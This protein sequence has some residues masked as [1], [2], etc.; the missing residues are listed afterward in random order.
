ML[1][2]KKLQ[3]RRTYIGGSD[4]CAVLGRDPRTT[5]LGVYCAKVD[6]IFKREDHPFLENG[7]DKEP[8]NREKFAK[9]T[10]L[11]VL[12]VDEAKHHPK[13]P[14]IAGNVDGLVYGDSKAKGSPIAILEVKCVSHFGRK[15]W[16]ASVPIPELTMH[17]K[18]QTPHNRRGFEQQDGYIPERYV[19]QALLYA[20]VYELPVVYF[21]VDFGMDQYLC[22]YK[23]ERNLELENMV[24]DYLA[25]F[26]TH[27]IEKQIPPEPVTLDD[28]KL[29]YPEVKKKA[30]IEASPEIEDT[31]FKAKELN[32]Q[33]DTLNGEFKTLKV[34]IADY[35]GE[36]EILTDQGGNRLATY[37]S[38]K[39]KG[40][41]D[42][43]K[44]LKEYA[45]IHDKY[46]KPGTGK[47]SRMFKPI[48]D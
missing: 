12:T 41:F 48:F 24:M 11:G 47:P 4:V 9:V 39:P 44:L 14:F 16:G 3:E 21:A 42:R 8:E 15:N 37:N 6:G 13:Y 32:N 25:H 40:K 17:P 27:N 46:W 38:M 30:K 23:Y 22:T 33:I 20:A 19:Y 43:A 5:P 31:Y 34:K 1:D 28:V 2:E 29:L 10:G 35:M 7:N 26:W 36:N 45:E 18:Y